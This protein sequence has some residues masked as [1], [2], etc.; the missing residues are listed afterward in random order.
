M[1]VAV[2]ALALTLLVANAFDV[3]AQTASP[4]LSPT[5]TATPTAT[6][7]ATPDTLPDAG[8]S[9][10]T[11]LGLVLGAILVIGSLLLAL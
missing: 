6:A 8:I 11:F 7:S 1:L 3:L 5:P 2:F 10:P 4:N 9:Y